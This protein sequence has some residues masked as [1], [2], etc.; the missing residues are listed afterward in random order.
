MPKKRLAF[1]MYSPAQHFISFNLPA[2]PIILIT[3]DCGGH[4]GE[5]ARTFICT[6]SHRVCVWY[7]PRA[8]VCVASNEYSALLCVVCNIR[9]TVV[10]S[11]LLA[12]ADARINYGHNNN[13]NNNKTTS[14]N[15]NKTRKKYYIKTKRKKKKKVRIRIKE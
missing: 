14:I 15:I 4:T 13:N 12:I 5:S 3:P 6:N 9:C 8:A 2:K 1:E 7:T 10:A 11:S